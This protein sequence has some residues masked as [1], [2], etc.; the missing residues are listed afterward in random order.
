MRV[1][2]PQVLPPRSVASAAHR[3]RRSQ[4]ERK[5]SLGPA[6]AGWA[7]QEAGGTSPECTCQD[8]GM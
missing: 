1:L 5:D 6:G 4:R 2:P 8:A 3:R 7:P